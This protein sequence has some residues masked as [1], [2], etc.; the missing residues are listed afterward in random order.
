MTTAL[1]KAIESDPRSLPVLAEA[2]GVD[3]AVL[4][5]FMRR[6]RS[7]KLSTSDRICKALGV[8]C[9]LIRRRK[10]GR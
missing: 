10:V 9:R 8:E 7:M 4:S 5:R 1:T 6:E 2:A 3:K